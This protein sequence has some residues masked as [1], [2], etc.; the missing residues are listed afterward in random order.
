MFY[1]PIFF[2]RTIA[3]WLL[4]FLVIVLVG[5]GGKAQEAN[6]LSEPKKEVSPEIVHFHQVVKDGSLQDLQQ[7]LKSGIDINAP[8]HNGENALMVAIAGKNSE[9][10]KLLLEQGADPEQTDNSNATAL[11]HAV[12][13]EYAD[14][15]RL[16]LKRGVDR[17]YHPKYPLK[18][19]E[20]DASWFEAGDLTMP[21]EIKEVMTEEEWKQSIKETLDSAAALGMEPI[22]A[23]ASNVE[24]LNLFLEAGDDL[25]RASPEMKRLLLKLGDEEKFQATLKDYQTHKSPRFGT[26][27][28]ERMDNPF[29]KDMIRIGCNAYIAREHFKDTDAFQ[30]GAVWCYDRFGSSL[31]PLKDGRFVQIGGEHEDYYDPDFLIY[32]DVVIHD[33][34][35]GIQIYGYPKEVFPPT[36]FHS[37][38]LV[39]DAIYLIGCLG[40]P[41]QRADDQTPV[42]RLKLNS[43]E[44]EAVK[45]TGEVPNWLYNHHARYEPTRNVIH[46]EGGER[47][48]TNQQGEPELV[49]N[50]EEFE[51][52]LST[53]QWRKLK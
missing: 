23:D 26:R 44:I 18:T 48:I 4:S 20:Y 36:D 27:N 22:I 37:A 21:E 7:L 52:D 19:I 3:G 17:G 2:R 1:S 38:T 34:K 41:E 32:N 53:L 24:I 47:Q 13:Q 14:G 50:K 8:G 31:T 51:L 46:V 42:Y 33:G 16:L 29:W 10:L 45:T 39:A 15:V 9:K 6:V 25:S 35:G 49:P 11:R 40:Y 43:W 5:C 28:P 12:Y 30:N